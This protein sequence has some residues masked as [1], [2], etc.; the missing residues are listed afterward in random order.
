MLANLRYFREMNSQQLWILVQATILLPLTALALRF[1]SFSRISQM[2]SRQLVNSNDGED[3]ATAQ[4]TAS[5]VYRVANKLPVHSTC[6]SRSLVLSYILQSQH[7]L[8]EIVIGVQ[9]SPAS[10]LTAHAW[11]QVDEIPLQQR[12]D[13]KAEYTRLYT[14]SDVNGLPID[15]V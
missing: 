7:I 15:D 4:M 6:L 13:V 10:P 5:L 1:L 3:L 9:K 14:T 12:S 8:N 2:L 11:V